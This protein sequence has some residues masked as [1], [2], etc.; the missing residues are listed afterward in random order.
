MRHRTRKNEAFTLAELLVVM[1]ILSLLVMIFLP[2]FGRAVAVSRRVHC[3]E[4]LHH[5]ATAFGAHRADEAMRGL[6]PIEATGWIVALEPFLAHNPKALVCPEDEGTML[7]TPDVKMFV[8]GSGGASAADYFINITTAYPYWLE[9]PCRDV[10]PPPG[11]WKVPEAQLYAGG[12]HGE[13]L[14]LAGFAGGRNNTELLPIYTPGPNPHVYWYLVETARYGDDLHAGGDLDYD[15]IVIRVTENA[16]TRRM[17]MEPIRI[18]RGQAYNLIGPDGT[19]WP[20]GTKNSED[21]RN[22]SVGDSGTLGPYYFPMG[23]ASYGMSRFVT[24][25]SDGMRKILALDYEQEVVNVG[26]VAQIDDGWDRLRAPRH[27]GQSNVLFADG[28]VAAMDLDAIDPEIDANEAQYW[29]PDR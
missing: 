20:S 13:S 3:A 25:M 21:N 24:E 17:T 18:W 16:A 22:N 6:P 29:D 1:I 23:N 11:I 26:P 5:V 12:Y 27:L 2:S 10:D 9:M 7:Y 4:N 14:G 19:W 8:W 28:G 15:D